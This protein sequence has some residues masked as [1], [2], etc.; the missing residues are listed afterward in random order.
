M[1][2]PGEAHQ[3]LHALVGSWTGE[4]QIQPSPWY[5]ADGQ[6]D[7]RLIP[8][9]FAVVHVYTQR[10]NDQVNLQGQGAF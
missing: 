8:G 7:N 9:R 2:R 1:P 6:V 4:E 5:P 10:R 3:K